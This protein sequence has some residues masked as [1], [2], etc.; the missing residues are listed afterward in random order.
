M[1]NIE[2]FEGNKKLSN[3]IF[4]KL[5]TNPLVLSILLL[6]TILI[7]HSG[8][9]FQFTIFPVSDTSVVFNLFSY[10][11]N[12]LVSGELPR[13]NFY[14]MYGQPFSYWLTL[15]SPIMITG[16][17]LA[18]IFGV[19]DNYDSYLITIFL[20]SIIFLLGSYL[21]CKELR[22][23]KKIIIFTLFTLI[24]TWIWTTSLSTNF[25]SIYTYPFFLLFTFTYLKDGKLSSLIYSGLSL[26]VTLV[27]SVGYYAPLLFYHFIISTSVIII[28]RYLFVRKEFRLKIF[29]I[30]KGFIAAIIFSSLMIGSYLWFA[31]NVFGDTNIE[32]IR[33]GRDENMHIF[34]EGL[35]AVYRLY[36]KEVILQTFSGLPVGKFQPTVHIG[37]IATLGCLLTIVL[38]KKINKSAG[39]FILC[40]T[41]T[42][43]IW[44][45]ICLLL[46]LDPYISRFI[47]LIKYI[48]NAELLLAFYRI[49]LIFIGA[50]GLNALIRLE[51]GGISHNNEPKNSPKLILYLQKSIK[52]LSTITLLCILYLVFGLPAY[53][54]GAFVQDKT[55]Y[56]YLGSK[57]II[58]FGLFLVSHKIGNKLK[59]SNNIIISI[60]LLGIIELTFNYYLLN[61]RNY[62]I[63]PTSSISEARKITS[64]KDPTPSTKMA[65]SIESL[66]KRFRPFASAYWANN[67]S[68]CTPRTGNDSIS[69]RLVRLMKEGWGYND[70]KILSIMNGSHREVSE[71][72]INLYKSKYTGCDDSILRP[73]TTMKLVTNTDQAL[74]Y[75]K[76]YEIN[77]NSDEQLDVI[78]D[79]LGYLEDKV[80]GIKPYNYYLKPLFKQNK[81]SL[82]LR[83]S[84]SPIFLYLAQSYN[85][86]WKIN[87]DVQGVKLFP[88]NVAF[89]GIYIPP[90]ATFIQLDYTDYYKI[91]LFKL[92]I[93]TSSLA[94]VVII[95]ISSKRILTSFGK[96]IDNNTDIS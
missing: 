32:F 37:S 23:D 44:T 5:I 2:E 20:E 56:A 29:V 55:I 30:D 76:S 13:W 80:E 18:S 10:I 64:L 92:L 19:S 27:G 38:K 22:I 41:S 17:W 69:S 26:A 83:A 47:P 63:I 86:K 40:I 73:L 58:L 25:R 85:N 12:N 31:L 70:E 75:I 51:D 33:P 53:G 43:L 39:I 88:A 11:N 89:T 79:N 50:V 52:I 35:P 71:I 60:L 16:S 54:F 65:N 81:I 62:N 67:F 59:A 82:D 4:L 36:F 42:L 84:N 68:S 7:L 96:I 66:G 72:P 8:S 14:S 28:G 45:T 1:K 48:N 61:I 57:L 49:Q 46:R 34:V 9:I 87:S 77:G 24:L 21:L 78:E 3:R 91:K 93:L 90:K 94:M 74:S 6:S 15:I 95:Y